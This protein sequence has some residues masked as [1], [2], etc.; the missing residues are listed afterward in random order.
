MLKIALYLIILPITVWSM[1]GLNLNGLFKQSRVY[2]AR[3]IILLLS[4]GIT[5]L[6]VNFFYDFFISFKLV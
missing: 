4:I 5:Y 1:D 2:Q 3:L 6:A